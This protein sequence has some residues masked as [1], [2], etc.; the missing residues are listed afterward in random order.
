[1]NVKGVTS[2]LLDYP[3]VAMV[4]VQVGSDG[5]VSDANIFRSSNNMET[6]QAVL[7]AAEG[8]SY[9]PAMSNCHA[10]A[11]K[12][13]LNFTNFNAASGNAVEI[14]GHWC[15]EADRVEAIIVAETRVNAAL[16]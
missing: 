6:D 4:Y 5:R 11:A 1:V 12:L 9:L 3:A 14:L 10:V 8:A 13:M 2:P 7:E 15:G 16:Y